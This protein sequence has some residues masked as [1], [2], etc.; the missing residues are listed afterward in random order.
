MLV[1]CSE[2]SHRELLPCSALTLSCRVL[3]PVFQLI[4]LV[5]WSTPLLFGF[6]LSNTMCFVAACRVWIA[7]HYLIIL[8]LSSQIIFGGDQQNAGKVSLKCSE[9]QRM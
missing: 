4:V 7:D 3:V 5:F 1:A 9:M 6:I 2:K 8:V